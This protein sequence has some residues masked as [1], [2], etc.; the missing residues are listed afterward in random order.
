MENELE[1]FHTQ[2]VNSSPRQLTRA[3]KSRFCKEPTQLSESQNHL[4]CPNCQ[5]PV[6]LTPSSSKVRP[7]SASA[8]QV[9]ESP[10]QRR[11]HPEQRS[12]LRP[13]STLSRTMS[14]IS[15]KSHLAYQ[16]DSPKSPHNSAQ[17][18]H[19]YQTG[20]LSSVS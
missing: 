12:Q 10:P 19:T 9:R 5:H 13:T 6:L 1:E 3:T 15:P 14:D 4:N 7:R 2:A 11:P 17:S 16:N 18:R 20:D 8:R